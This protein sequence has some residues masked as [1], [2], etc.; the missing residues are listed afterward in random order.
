MIRIS[1]Q[2]IVAIL[3]II[4]IITAATIGSGEK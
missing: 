2:T 1:K 3:M 4:A